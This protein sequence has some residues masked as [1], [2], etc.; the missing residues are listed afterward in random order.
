MSGEDVPGGPRNRS[1][2]RRRWLRIGGLAA[3]GLDLARPLRADAGEAARRSPAP[4]RSCILIFYYGGPSHLD[5]WDPKPKA[6]REVRGEFRPI[7][8]SVPGI[9]VSEHLPHSAC[10]FDRLVIVRSLH[11]PMTNHNAAAFATLSGRSPARGDLELLNDNANDPPCLGSLLSPQLPGRR[12]LPTFVALP[13][14]M[15]NVV[16]LP[17]QIAGFLGSAHNP[18]Q[19]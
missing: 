13:H 17:G 12:D 8:T 19:V 14:V 6:P 1:L 10:V 2:T 11:H 9:Q 5:T 15:Y 16:R 18:F 4:V 7:A 3:L